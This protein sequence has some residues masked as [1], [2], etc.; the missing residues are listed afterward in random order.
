[1]IGY[2]FWIS[3]ERLF[4]SSQPVKMHGKGLTVQNHCCP[5]KFDLQPEPL[6]ATTFHLFYL[7]FIFPGPV[8]GIHNFIRSIVVL[9][10]NEIPARNNFNL[11]SDANSDP[12]GQCH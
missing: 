9:P 12:V 5:V 1:M 6:V 2:W 11:N 7:L 3:N 4:G 10:Y 8:P